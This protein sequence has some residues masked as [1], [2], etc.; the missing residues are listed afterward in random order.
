MVTLDDVKN[1][2]SAIRS[3][4]YLSPFGPSRTLSEWTGYNVH[5]KLENLQMTGSFKER[6]ALNKLLSLS[7]SERSR[8]VIAASAGN[9]AQGVAYN[10]KVLGISAT[11][12]MPEPTPLIKVAATRGFGAKVVL[13]GSN[14]DEAYAHALE[15]AKEEDLVFIH[16]F[17]DPLTVAGQGTIGLE[18][19]E[20][21]PFLEAAV[22][23]VGGGGLI[24]GLSV[25]LKETNPNIK[26]IGV[27]AE[28]CPCMKKSLEQ[29]KIVEV[30]SSRSLADGIAVKRVGEVTF[31]IVR[32]Y[33]DQM[34]TVTEEEIAN[35]ILILIE[36][37]KTVVEGAGA[38]TL[39]AVIN[40]KFWIKERNIGLVISGG[41]IDVNMISRIIERGLAKDGRLVRFRVL[42]SDMPGEL[43]KTSGIIAACRAN[44]IMVNHER[45]FSNAPVG[46]ANVTFTIETRGR[47]HIDQIFQRLSEGGLEVEELK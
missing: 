7:P 24:A 35:A 33:V 27:E 37:E 11:I 46:T 41:N 5:L 4:I 22:V 40:Q 17:D 32:K 34:V 31:P 44:I 21:V 47:E 23:P 26:I 8:G 2:L 16:P 6:G 9:H 12:V 25:A 28:A 18:M 36:Q 29:G 3:Q 38:A 39:A 13:H 14:Y 1:A 10:A 15:L 19:L 45:G 30:A 43:H 20:Q 42:L